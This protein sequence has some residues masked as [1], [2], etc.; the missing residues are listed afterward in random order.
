M[1]LPAPYNPLTGLTKKEKR[2]FWL[3]FALTIAV[4]AVSY[5]LICIFH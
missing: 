3:S 2:E 1:R 4:L 5:V